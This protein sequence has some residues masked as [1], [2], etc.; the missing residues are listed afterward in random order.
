MSYVSRSTAFLLAL[1][2]L[3][4]LACV[5]FPQNRFTF[6]FSCGP[7]HPR[8]LTTP[9]V[10]P[11]APDPSPCCRRKVQNPIHRFPR[12]DA[13]FSVSRGPFSTFKLDPG[14][15][16]SYRNRRLMPASPESSVGTTYNNF[17]HLQ[18]SEFRDWFLTPGRWTDMNKSGRR[19]GASVGPV[20]AF[21]RDMTKQ[22]VLEDRRLT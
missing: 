7:R 19:A 16:P 20:R 13:R 18:H 21:R 2:L 17:L 9:S 6:F 8:A 1:P 11:Q 12:P 10:T 15:S 3:R 4:P 22:N 14:V 5:L